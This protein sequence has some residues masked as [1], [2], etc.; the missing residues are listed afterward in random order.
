MK[1]RIFLIVCVVLISICFIFVNI[2]TAKADDLS[3]SI[4]N[5]IDNIDFSEFKEYL[6]GIDTFSD[7]DFFSYLSDM[8]KGEYKVNFSSIG[9]YLLK[10]LLSKVYELLPVFISVIA[11]AVFCG[12]INGVK[13]NLLSDRTSDIIFFVCFLSIILILS[14]T[15][16]SLFQETKVVIENISKLNEIMSPIILTLMVASGGKVSAGVYKP[17][18]SLLS[19][20]IINL[21]LYVIFP[22]VII[23]TIFHVLSNFSSSIKFKKFSQFISSLIKWVI[24]ISV[25]V[26]SFFMTAQGI[27]SASIDGISLRA[28]KYAISNSI[29]LIGGFLKDGFDIVI[30]GSVLIKNAVGIMGLFSLFFIILS[31]V[32]TIA[33]VSLLFRLV[34]SLTEPICDIRI[35][36][37]CTSISSGISYLV[38]CILMVGF[39]FFISVL[40]MIFS[41]NAFI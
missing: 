17:V 21:I 22:L 29:P 2:T 26:F 19:G 9:D 24:G 20:G 41:A 25:T 8:I 6:D 32:I 11:I 30:A 34:A 5:Q 35:S 31:P 39:M 4:Q 40:L 16:F 13:G 3:D 7:K 14:G 1:K 28:T 27:T 18:V 10:N 15:I 12:L 37:F 38:V 36:D 33:V 23:M